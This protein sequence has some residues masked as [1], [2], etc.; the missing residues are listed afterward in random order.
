MEKQIYSLNTGGDCIVFA[1]FTGKQDK[2]GRDIIK[3]WDNFTGNK[4]VLVPVS[5]YSQS[6]EIGHKDDPA[7]FYLSEFTVVNVNYN[8]TLQQFN[9]HI[10]ANIKVLE[11]MKAKAE[12]TGKRVNGY[13]AEMLEMAIN[14]YKNIYSL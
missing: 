2:Q 14:N 8:C 12:R 13:T 5:K 1:V 7:K 9:D 4:P 10:N 3:V 6:F 11:E